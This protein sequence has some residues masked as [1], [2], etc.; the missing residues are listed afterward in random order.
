MDNEN[1]KIS[2]RFEP[3]V[4]C[5]YYTRKYGWEEMNE[6]DLLTALKPHYELSVEDLLWFQENRYDMMVGNWMKIA[7]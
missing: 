4:L 2:P 7:V 3:C 5:C 6:I 1:I